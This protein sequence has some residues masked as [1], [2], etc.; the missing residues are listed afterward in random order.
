MT[1][2]SEDKFPPISALASL[3]VVFART[4]NESDPTFVSRL[5]ENIEKFYR[6]LEDNTSARD[7]SLEVLA[8]TNFL[9]GRG[10]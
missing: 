7:G 1:I 3:A 4:L 8:Y 10:E 2:P 9:F 6:E 5:R